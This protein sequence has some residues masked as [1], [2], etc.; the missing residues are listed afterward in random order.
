MKPHVTIDEEYQQ[1]AELAQAQC[2]A[3][4]LQIQRNEDDLNPDEP[5]KLRG[6]SQDKYGRAYLVFQADDSPRERQIIYV[7][8]IMDLA[9]L[10][11]RERVLPS[12]DRPRE[13]A[14]P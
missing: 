4:D 6:I 5:E 7:D 14:A 8:A 1:L 13:R 9:N 11:R 2:E 12:P 3:L 10:L